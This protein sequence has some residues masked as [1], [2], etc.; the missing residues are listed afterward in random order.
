MDAVL[1]LTLVAAVAA[2]AGAVVGAVAGAVVAGAV[3]GTAVGGLPDVAG[4]H[5]A[6]ASVVM[7]AHATTTCA[8]R[9]RGRTGI[10]EK[11]T[12]AAWT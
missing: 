6:S 4:P 1:A 9:N 7:A 11:L 3:V 8:R 2:L 5:A 10:A 12:Q